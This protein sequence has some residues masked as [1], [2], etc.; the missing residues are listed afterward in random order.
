MNK[1]LVSGMATDHEA[2]EGKLFALYEEWWRVSEVA[3]KGDND[4]K[5]EWDAVWDAER[6]LLGT[7]AL[8]LADLLFKFRYA[9]LPEMN[10]GSNEKDGKPAPSPAVLAV[11]RDL[12]GMLGNAQVPHP[13]D[14]WPDD[15]NG[16]MQ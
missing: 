9:C 16:R 10:E 11:L 6:R 15:H 12:E 5:E 2:P 14:H 13:V 8:T 3:A 4:N 1:R 7:P